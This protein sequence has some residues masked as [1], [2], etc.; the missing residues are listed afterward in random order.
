MGFFKNEANSINLRVRDQNG[1]EMLVKSKVNA[2]FSRLMEAYSLK[3]DFRPNELRFLFDGVRVHE[4]DTPDKDEVKDGFIKMKIPCT[5]DKIAQF[6]S[7]VDSDKDGSVSFNEFEHY[8]VQNLIQLRKLFNELDVNKSGTLDYHEI[9]DSIG[10]LQLPLYSEQELTRIFHSLDRNND[11][12]IDFNE[13]REL[14]VLLPN[15]SLQAVLAYWKDAQILDGGAD[16]GG[17]APPPPMTAKNTT[18]MNTL[19]YMAAGAT[20]GIVS[21][22]L[23][24]PIERVKIIYQISHGAPKSLLETFKSVYADGGVRGLFRGNFANILKVAPESAVKFAT[25]EAVKRVFAEQDSQLT[26][27]QRFTSGAVAGVVS[28]STLFPLEV[29]RTRLSASATGTYSGI[30]DC[31]RQTHAAEGMRP[32]FRGL[33]AS[34]L[35]TIPH[36]GINMWI[37]ESLKQE[38]IKR[39]GGL[40]PTTSDLLF[41]ATASSIAGQLAGYPFHVVKTRLVTQGTPINPEKYNGV[42]H[43]LTTIVKKEGFKGLYRGILPN[44]MKSIPSHGITFLV[45]EQIK[46]T[47]NI[48]KEKKHH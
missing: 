21:R 5:D 47:F 4:H 37:Y 26:G 45:Y 44:F 36:S 43:G 48:K 7:A 38:I 42:V 19:S 2:P 35:S 3:T 40:A 46:A 33:S 34:I 13:W 16:S 20:A 39:S 8:T 17:F 12:Q 41:C 11:N 18:L 10:K 25:F 28:H 27:M 24:A 31:V 22:T 1:D 30:I 6:M 23:T 32:F 14:L 15:S 29:V 9:E